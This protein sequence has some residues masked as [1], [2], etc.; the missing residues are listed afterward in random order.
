[1]HKHARWRRRWRIMSSL[2]QLVHVKLVDVVLVNREVLALLVSRVLGIDHG[3]NL[4][5]HFE[6]HF[7][8]RNGSGF[9]AILQRDSDVSALVHRSAL[10]ENGVQLVLQ[11]LFRCIRRHVKQGSLCGL[12]LQSLGEEGGGGVEPDN[13]TV[14]HGIPVLQGRD[15]ASARGDEDA[16]VGLQLLQH[17]LLHLPEERLA[18]LIED[19]SHALTSYRFHQFVRIEEGILQAVV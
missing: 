7:D 6:G 1:M 17:L 10:R 9:V 8:R 14:A 16:G 2:L 5:Q 11:L 4:L 19:F 12:P 13:Q 15:D 18:S 3:F